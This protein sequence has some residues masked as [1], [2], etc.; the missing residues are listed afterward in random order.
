M[1]ARLATLALLA[2]AAAA[3]VA[4]EAPV[5]REGVGPYFRLALPPA[6]Y[7]LS[8]RPALDD[9]RLLDAQR[10]PLAWAWAP[11][12]AADGDPLHQDLPLFPLPDEARP[13]AGLPASIRIG[14]DGSVLWQA[15]RPA[16]PAPATPARRWLLDAH[17]ARGN[18]LSL[19]LQ[20]QGSAQGVFPLALEASDDLRHWRPLNPEAAVLHL[21]RDGQQLHQAEVALDAAQA[22][23]L[24]LTWLGQP[25]ALSRATVEHLDQRLPAPALQWTPPRPPDHCDER[26]CTW[27]LPPRLPLDALR[28]DLAEPNTVAVVR[29]FEPAAPAAQAGPFRR[30]H[31][32]HGLRH[33]HA[34]RGGESPSPHDIEVWQG[35]LWR[36]DL[37]TASSSDASRESRQ[38]VIALDG[39]AS[40]SLRL[41]ARQSTREWGSTPPTL[42]LATRSRELVFLARG[43]GPVQLAWGDPK[44]PGQPLA[45]G[46]L[47]P[48]GRDSAIGRASVSLPALTFPALP[49]EPAAAPASGARA[50]AGH[51]PWLW[52][53]LAA[54]LL[55]LAGMA[56]SLLRSTREAPDG[57]GH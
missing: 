30:H 34:G 56:W 7:G 43:T 39:R 18:L 49:L 57:A 24:R 3:A 12:P 8:T 51:M 53:A 16:P 48:L 42:S 2:L 5:S 37:N 54:G 4:G 6:I 21:E 27:A 10:Q 17:G 50:D 55:L 9:L 13:E 52:A 20:W 45:T 22:P 41:E 25:L 14:A 32:L 35:V 19:D 23:Y 11:E 15:G 33:R 28:L 46:E 31:A 36:L 40:P 29:L 47:M 44:A 38:P 26:A 1:N